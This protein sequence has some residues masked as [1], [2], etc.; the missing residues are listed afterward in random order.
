MNNRPAFSTASFLPLL[1]GLAVGL[2]LVAVLGGLPTKWGVFLVVGSAFASVLLLVG[3]FSTHLRG[4]MLFFAVL[5]L[6]TFYS[7]TFQFRELI[8]FTVL[9]NGFPVSITDVFLAPLVIGWL[10][11][12]M[13]D[14]RQRQISFPKDWLWI[15]VLLLLI[16]FASCLF[17]SRIPFFSLSMLYVQAKMYFIMF[18]LA[19]YLQD[20]HDFR[21]MGYAF[22][23]VLLFEGLVVMEQR[24]L[25]V[26]FTQ[27]NMRRA[28]GIKSL[29][30]GGGGTIFRAAG[31]LSHPNDMAMYINLC[32]PLVAFMYAIETKLLRKVFLMTCIL[33]G[34]YALMSSGSR[35]AWAGMGVGFAAGIFLWMRKQ[36]K[37]P[38]FGMS[39]M[40]LSVVTLFTALF[41]GS[42][43]FHDRIIKGDREAAQVRIPLMEVATEMIQ[44]NPAMGVGLNL[45]TREMV[46]YDRTNYMVTSSFP[47]PVHN[48]FLLVAAETGLP[49]MALL[50]VFIILAFKKSV[51]VAKEG[52]GIVSAIGL[53]VLT[54][55][56][57]WLI[58]NQVN[59]STV[60]GDSTFYVLLG[61]LAAAINYLNRQQLNEQ[62][63]LAPPINRA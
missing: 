54:S 13:T 44:A 52:Q 22:A 40:F 60:Y 34:V 28:I 2:G 14:P 53:G 62:E 61:M 4:S 18:F 8:P 42:A 16:N 3:A 24:M 43:T 51:R 23:A 55:L 15:I 35:G 25:G 63:A 37:N 48:T 29:V 19:N 12:L 26:I 46:P 47:E 1:F 30:A 9:A 21:V 49:A 36:G 56:I 11:R 27:E 41:F 20:E 6:P 58:H 10:Y 31:T 59:H 38:I 17:V 7:I 5:G 33:V 50:S 45:Y 57:C 32:L 39:I